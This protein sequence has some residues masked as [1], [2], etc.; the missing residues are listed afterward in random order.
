MAERHSLSCRWFT[1][2]SHFCYFLFF[3]RT[4]RKAEISGPLSEEQ[5]HRYHI[6]AMIA[7]I[8]LIL[9]EIISYFLSA[10]FQ[11]SHLYWIGLTALVVIQSSQRKTIQTSFKRILVNTAGALITF[12]LSVISFHRHFG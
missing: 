8:S 1:R 9:A 7:V 2:R 10:H 12:E 3:I 11:F 6:T 4:T 5:T